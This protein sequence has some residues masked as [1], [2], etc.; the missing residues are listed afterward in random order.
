MGLG[1]YGLGGSHGVVEGLGVS[2]Y[3]LAGAL[4]A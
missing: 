3:V 1:F 4:E 2:A